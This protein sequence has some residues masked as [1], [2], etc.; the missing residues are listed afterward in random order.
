MKTPAE[1]NASNNKEIEL[2]LLGAATSIESS[3]NTLAATKE[4]SNPPILNT[5]ALVTPAGGMGGKLDIDWTGPIAPLLTK[6]ADVTGY[7]V[8]ILGREPAIPVIVSITQNRAIIA[9]ILKNASLQAGR[10]ASV[11]VFPANRVIELR[12]QS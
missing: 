4:T 9:D 3:L 5:S 2:Q 10:S 6:L 7:E 11:L 12:Y 1:V 8:K